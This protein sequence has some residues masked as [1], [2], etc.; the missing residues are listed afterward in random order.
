M[1]KWITEVQLGRSTR[2]L[3]GCVKRF[4]LTGLSNVPFIHTVFQ[5]DI[6]DGLLSISLV[7]YIRIGARIVLEV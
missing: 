4:E 6:V 5:C 3:L 7:F 1:K 2:L